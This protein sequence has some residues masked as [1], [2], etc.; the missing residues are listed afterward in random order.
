MIG[1]ISRWRRDS[2]LAPNMLVVADGNLSVIAFMRDKIRPTKGIKHNLDLW[3]NNKNAKK[4][5]AKACTTK[6]T[7][8]SIWYILLIILLNGEGKPAIRRGRNVIFCPHRTRNCCSPGSSMWE[9]TSGGARSTAVGMQNSWWKWRGPVC[10]MSRTGTRT[11]LTT[12]GLAAAMSPT[13]GE[14]DA[15]VKYNT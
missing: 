9:T 14:S 13:S 1:W 2:R 6:V 12:S 4:N 3:H 10:F 11:S 7:Y 8:D 5:L 15:G